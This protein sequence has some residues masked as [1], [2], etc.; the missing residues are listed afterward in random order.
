M[1]MSFDFSE[2][3]VSIVLNRLLIDKTTGK[4]ILWATDSYS[5]L[6]E[7][8]TSKDEIQPS[9]LELLSNSLLIPRIMKSVDLQ[10]QRTKKHAEVFTPGWIVNQMVNTID[11]SWF[12]HGSPFNVV[13]GKEWET[14]ETQI[15]FDQTHSWQDYVA[16][17]ILEITC[18]EA[19]YLVSR[20]DVTNG[21]TIKLYNRIGVLDR[22]LRVITENTDDF[23]EWLQWVQIAYQSVYGY[24]Y[25]GDNLLIARLN[26]FMT[27]I[28]YYRKKW[29]KNPD[30]HELRKIATIISWNLWQMDGLSFTVPGGP[31]VK[32]F[33][34]QTLDLFE[35]MV[36]LSRAP[37]GP[38]KIYNWRSKASVYFKDLGVKTMGKKLFDFVIGNP[39][40]QDSESVNNRS[41][42]VYNYFYDSAKVLA[43]KY[44]L[45]SPAR[46][47]FNTGLTPKDWNTKML[48]DPHLLI[49]EYFKRSEEVFPNT[50]IM[51]GLV[52]AYYDRERDFGIIDTFIPNPHLRSIFNHFKRMQI[53]DSLSSIMYGGR[54]D[55]KF[56]DKF[57]NDYPEVPSI[58]LNKIKDKHKNVSKLSPNEEYELK[59]S[60]F[61]TLGYYFLDKKPNND[62]E[63]YKIIGLLNGKRVIR[64]IKKIY[65]DPRYP[66]NNNILNYKVFVPESNGSGAIGEVLSTPLIGTPL[67]GTPLMSSTPTFISI[68]KFNSEFEASACLKYVKSKFLRV[69]LGVLKTT[70]HNPVSLWRL[71][72]LQDFTSNSDINW[73]QSIHDIDHQLYKKYE[74]NEDDINFIE[75]NVKEMS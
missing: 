24:E 49:K 45:I 56:N 4:N 60:S 65:M 20:Y 16:L 28:D 2:Y 71:I 14:V 52:I 73:N 63:Y 27:F 1:R 51:G 46:F 58:L 11:E 35:D 22:K 61:D 66:E 6:G 3:P 70:Q 39:P 12:N 34:L 50:D 31:L 9:Q 42:A 5:E 8:F 44:I 62:F 33:E 75:S 17:K 26:L 36:E 21:E 48:H 30:N 74:F 41:G 72:P 7:G 69:L 19:P 43:N 55:L 37:V 64:W 54:S 47:L 18:G 15:P 57:L 67:I 59:S 25:Q 32:T 10:I 38:C 29:N 53:S 68:G 13:S 40:Y 23:G